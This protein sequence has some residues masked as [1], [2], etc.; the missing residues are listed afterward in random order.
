MMLIVSFR[1]G[2]FIPMLEVDAKSQLMLKV[3]AKILPMLK[4]DVKSQLMLKVYAKRL[5]MLKVD[6]KSLFSCCAWIGTKKIH[7]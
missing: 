3:D 6:A 1:V 4:V 2:I 5:P 7:P